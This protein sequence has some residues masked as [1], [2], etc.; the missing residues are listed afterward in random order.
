MKFRL[1]HP[2]I[3]VAVALSCCTFASCSDDD[4]DTPDKPED[5]EGT[6]ETLTPAAGKTF[7][8][9]VATEALEKFRAGDQRDFI[10]LASYYDNTYSGYDMPKEFDVE[11]EE[12]ENALRSLF[13][14]LRK[15]VENGDASGVTE[16]I[17]KYTYN[18]N[19][20]RFT[21]IYEP[22]RNRW[23][24]TDDSNDIIF[25]FTGETGQTCELRAR[26]S[27]S[28]S[29]YTY[30]YTDEEYIGW[31]EY[32]D[33][34]YVYNCA[35]PK[36][37]VITLT[38]GDKEIVN[39]EVNSDINVNGHKMSLTASVKVMN[40]LAATTISGTDSQITATTSLKVSDEALISSS[41]TINGNNLCNLDNYLKEPEL[42]SLFRNGTATVS[43]LNKV[44]VDGQI[45]YNGI[46]EDILDYPHWDSSDY[47][48]MADAEAAARKDIATLNENIK[49]QLRYNNKETVQANLSWGITFDSRGSYSSY[50][51]YGTEPLLKFV[52][53]DTEYSFS[54]YFERGFSSIE[55][56][57]SDLQSSY[58]RVWDSVNKR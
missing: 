48:S 11:A 27:D 24:R 31:G 38:S 49:A 28:T 3:L 34:E 52:Q 1:K 33:V 6:M 30:S 25:R 22:G 13:R 35:V 57:W 12:D 15:S 21:G 20:K 8:K 56:L 26:A 54:E 55:D 39:A 16:E 51:E 23:V 58:K 40:I 19:F 17:I 14:G 42:T 45:T 10:V 36:K 43:I 29:D 44:R 4:S 18:L 46:I 32:E 7:L 53:D 2:A 37:V 5:L 47:F 9:D 50:W 41:A